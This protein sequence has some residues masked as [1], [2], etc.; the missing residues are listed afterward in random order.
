[1]DLLKPEQAGFNRC[2]GSF[3][4]GR[5][6]PLLCYMGRCPH[7]PA[8]AFPQGG[9][10]GD[11][12]QPRFSPQTPRRSPPTWTLPLPGTSRKIKDFAGSLPFRPRRKSIPPAVILRSFGP[13]NIRPAGRPILDGAPWSPWP[14]WPRA[15]V[16]SS[17][18]TPVS[19]DIDFTFARDSTRIPLARMRAPPGWK[20]FSMTIPAPTSSAPA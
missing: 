17:N 6:S 11:I 19:S 9:S 16:Q 18:S 10:S 13:A 12:P 2:W 14:A 5:R 1:M 7:R 15:P 4:R 3:R 20:A 8:G